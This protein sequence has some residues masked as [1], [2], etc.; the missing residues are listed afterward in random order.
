MV[1]GL[2]SKNKKGASVHV[3]YVI[4]IQEI[5]PWPPSQSLKSVRSVV[6][7]WENGDH[8]SGSANPATPSIGVSA[9]E[10]KIEFNESFKLQVT[11]LREGSAKGNGAGTFQKNV[12]EFNLYEPRRDKMVK[13][14]HLGSV[15]IDLAEHGIIKEAVS[16]SIPVSCKRSFRNTVQP[17]LYVKIQPFQ[18]DN[19]SSSSRESLSKEASFDKDGK[20]SVSALMN[21]EYAEEAEIAS[22]T[23]DDISSHSS[24]ACSSS[25]LEANADLPV[26]TIIAEQQHHEVILLNHNWWMHIANIVAKF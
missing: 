3:D 15:V 24:L 6:L 8:S 5:K 23:D 26:Q 16:V 11:L 1:L 4:H 22:F 9:A 13:G 18:K 20:E 25:A 12:L 21:E 10:G 17:L 2:R 7:Q 19:R 14:Q